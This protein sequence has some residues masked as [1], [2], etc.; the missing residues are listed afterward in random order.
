MS[1]A[2]VEAASE[3]AEP[4]S[5]ASDAWT[6]LALT[7]PI[8]LLYHLG[9]V[10]LPF[11]NAAD[12]VTSE[13]TSLAKESIALYLT[14]T[15][16]IGAIFGLV[17]ASLGKSRAL[18]PQR[19]LGMIV[20][21]AAYA[22][23]MR[24][25]GAWVL[26]TLPLQSTTGVETVERVDAALQSELFAD[27][28][29]SLG[30]GFYEELAF[31]VGLFGCGAWIIKTMEGSTITSYGLQIGWGLITALAFSGWHHMGPGADSFELRVFMYRAVCG[32]VLTL[33]FSLRGF[34][35][36]VWTHAI[37]DIWAMV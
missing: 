32:A 27:V 9:V 16:A 5:V 34:G 12:P 15:V 35:A 23:L 8:A 37:Y 28:V 36:A 7:L 17:L 10:F 33:I 14:L 20:E 25:A 1:A 30:A 11:R 31:R 6:N 18:A 3:E 19:L 24:L 26:Q 21:G 29:M 2:S 4:A 22:I 13:L